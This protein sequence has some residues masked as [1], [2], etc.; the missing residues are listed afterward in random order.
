MNCD[1]ARTL[2][3]I[4]VF[5]TLDTSDRRALDEHLRICPA[6][7]RVAE[8]T[9]GVREAFGVPDDLPQPNWEQSWNVIAARVFDRPT[10]FWQLGI[11]RGWV[12][13]AASLVVVF[14]LGVLAGRRLPLQPAP[15]PA[16]ETTTARTVPAPAERP[17]ALRRYADAV[18]PVLVEFTGRGATPLPPEA[19]E[20]QHRMLRSMIEETRML[21]K[22]AARAGDA[23]LEALL[24]EMEPLLVSIANLRPGDQ[25]SADQL[26]RVIREHEIRTKVRELARADSAS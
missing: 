14:V 18:E 13:A 23:E 8:K 22:L 26:K 21:R 11:P 19:S 6:C 16:E 15:G 24:D 9:A 10:R 12:L 3:T 17:S 7:A 5:G 4:D 1:E 20:T 2:V 25:G